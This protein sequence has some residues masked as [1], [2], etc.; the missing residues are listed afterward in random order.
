MKSLV[1]KL[2]QATR[3]SE[4]EIKEY[5][6]VPD[7]EIKSYLSQLEKEGLIEQTGSAWRLRRL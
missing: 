1:K 6:G 4:K 2:L 3:M 5:L 7:S